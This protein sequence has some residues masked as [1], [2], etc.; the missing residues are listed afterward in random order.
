M[1]GVSEIILIDSLFN[2]VEFLLL[3]AIWLFFTKLPQ[4]WLMAFSF[5]YTT[6]HIYILGYLSSTF[7]QTL[8]CSH[9]TFSNLFG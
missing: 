8:R 2:K 1:A 3:F 9:D 7:I 6:I 4:R 5:T